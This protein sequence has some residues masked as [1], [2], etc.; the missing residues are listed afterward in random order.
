MESNSFLE[1]IHKKIK[2]RNRR[3]DI[4]KST[5]FIVGLL[6]I[7]IQSVEIIKF[8]IMN[9]LWSEYNSETEVY[10]WEYSAEISDSQLF[11]YLIDEM[12]I[13]EVLQFIEEEQENLSFVETIKLGDK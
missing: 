1:N 5:T 9:N 7:T 8:E 2:R 13:D 6:L 4:V 12:E 10:E 3:N 11:S